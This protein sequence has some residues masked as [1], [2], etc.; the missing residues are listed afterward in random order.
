VHDV[1]D[2][3]ED[4]VVVLLAETAQRD[5]KSLSVSAVHVWGLQGGTAT[6]FQAFLA[7][8]YQ[9]DEFWS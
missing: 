2:N 8:E 5:D 3:G 4:K 6:T 9:V 7:D 1:L